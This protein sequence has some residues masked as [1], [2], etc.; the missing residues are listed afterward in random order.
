MW[1]ICYY[2]KLIRK[3]LN[4]VVSID[5]STPHSHELNTQPSIYF[6][7]WLRHRQVVYC[8]YVLDIWTYL[9]QL[10]LKE[11]PKYLARTEVLQLC[12]LECDFQLVHEHKVLRKHL[13]KFPSLWN[14]LKSVNSCKRLYEA[15]STICT[16]KKYTHIIHHNT[17]QM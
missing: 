9:I 3:Y 17:I 4:W 2:R 1:I 14:K 13:A 8:I 6:L 10:V 12:R 5:F 7:F 16:L 11:F 15:I